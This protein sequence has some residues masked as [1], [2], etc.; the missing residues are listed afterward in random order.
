MATGINYSTLEDLNISLGSGGDIF[1][2]ESTHAGTT[3]LW[4]NGGGDVVNVRTTAGQTTVDTGTGNDVI[5]V[6]SLSAV[7]GGALNA[8]NGLVVVRAGEGTDTLNVDDS[9]DIAD[10][11]GEMTATGITGLG[12]AVG[13]GI[14]YLNLETLNVW[15]GQG[16]DSFTMHSTHTQLTNVDGGPSGDIIRIED[17]SGMTNIYG[18]TGKD[19]ITVDT[20]SP[21]FDGNLDS[22]RD[23]V[24]LDGQAGTDNF[25]VN[26]TG[27]GDYIVNVF[28]TGAPDDGTDTLTVYGTDDRDDFLL[29]A[30]THD[31]PSGV[32]FV[33]SLHGTPVTPA[34][35]VER[36]N[37]NKNLEHLTVDA[38]RGEDY[39]T[40]DDNWTKT[41]IRGDDGNDH[42][43]VGQIFKSQRDAENANIAPTD[44]FE[45]VQTT[46][47]YL[48]NGVSF[49]TTIEGN[50]G[51]DEFT[52]FRNT[53]D[54]TLLGGD[55]DDTFTIRAFAL[56]GS[57]T[58]EVTGEGGAD[59]VL[60]VINS[61]VH[62]NGGD[63][64][65]TVRVIGTEFS[66]QIVVTKDGIF[67]MGITVDYT[68]IEHLV[69]DAAEGNDEFFILSTN[70]NV[71]TRLYGGLGS[72]RF[73]VAG[74]VPRIVQGDG[75]V[76]FP[77][78]AG[79]HKVD[80]IEGPLFISGAAGKGSAGG[81]GSPVMLPGETNVMPSTGDILE[82]IGTG[83]PGSIDTMMVLTSAL[84][85]VESDLNKLIGK[86]IEVSYGP[87]LGRF[88]LIQGWATAGDQTVLTL[89]SP[90]MPADEWG[91]PVDG[92]SK[93][94]VTHLSENFFIKESEQVDIT[95]I[96]NDK[97]TA[98]QTGAL[99]ATTLTGFGMNVEGITYGDLET[100]DMFLGT[101]KDTVSVTGTMKREDGFRTVTML[102]TGAGD[103]TVT[104]NLDSAKDGF[105]VLN[106]EA[107]DDKV[108][109]STSTLPLVIFGGEGKDTIQSGEGDDIVFG[110]KGRIDYRDD[111]GRIITR[112]GL[113]LEERTLI[114]PGGS[115]STVNDVPFR[116]TDGVVRGPAYITTRDSGTGD[117]DT[118]Y[119]NDGSDIILGGAARDIVVAGDG[120]NI[121][122]GDNGYVDYVA[123]DNDPTDIDLIA[124]T[125]YAIGGNDDITTGTGSDI[126]IGGAADDTVKAG[127]GNNIV[128]GDSGRITAAAS[129]ASRF[130][131]FSLTIGLIET[132]AY[133]IGG[134][135]TI[136]A[137]SSNTECSIILG[138]QAGDTI[139]AIDGNNIVLG[140]NGYVDYV[141][142]DGD[143]STIDEIK[144]T[145]TTADGGVDIITTGT[146][147]DIVIGGRYGDNVK[148]GSG[149]NIVL[150]DSGRL[151]YVNGKLNRIETIEPADGGID[152][153]TT[154][155]G[156]DII[157]GGQAG[158]I[159]N[160]G[161]GNN[162]VLGDNGYIDYVVADGDPSDIDRIYSTDYAV[163]G[164]DI[165]TTGIGSDIVIGGTADD[166][167]KA[168]AGDNIVIGDSGQVT[169]A[170]S[171][172]ARFAGTNLTIGLIETT[173]YGIGGVDDI[174]TNGGNDIILGGEA[175]DLPINAGDGNNIVLGDDG[176][177]R[178]DSD[179]DP[180]TIDEIRSTST[181]A[182]GGVDI[183]TTGIGSDIVIGGRYGDTVNAGA[184]NNIVLGDSGRLVYV[185]GSLNR[186]ETIEPADGGIDTITTNGGSDIILGGQ[187]GDII[188]AGE[189]T[190]LVL[191]DN[192]TVD[193]LNGFYTKAWTTDTSENTGGAD[194]ISGNGGGDYIL[195]GVGGDTIYGDAATPGTNDGNDV[196]LG[197]NGIFEFNLSDAPYDGDATTLD[198][199]QTADTGLGGVDTIYGNAKDDVI[200]GGAAGDFIYGNA[201]NDLVLGDFG[202]VRFGSVTVNKLGTSNAYKE[203]PLYATTTD[204]SQGGTDTIFG[205]EDEDVLAGGAFGDNIDGG[206]QDDLI[207]GD[208]VTLNR[209]GVYNDFTNPRFRTVTGPMYDSNGNVTVGTVNQNFPSPMGTP[210]WGNWDFTLLHHDVATEAPGNTNFG[211]DYIAG[212]PDDDMIFGQLGDDAIQGDGSIDSKVNGGTAVGA[213]RN[214]NG[215]LTIRPSFEA[216]TDG[217]D[218]IEGNGGNDVIFG[219]LGQDDIIGGS[220]NLFSLTASNLR[221][222]GSDVIFGGAGTDVARNNMG[223]ELVSGHA[224][225][226]DMIL[227]DN[228]NIFRLVSIGTNGS[229]YL[230]FNYDNYNSLKIVPRAADL[231]D[232]TPGGID[233]DAAAADDI[234]FA[235]EIHGESGDDFIY[236]MVGNDVLFGE[237][238]DDDLIGG[239]G[240]DWISGG[241]GQDGVLGDDGRIYSSRNSATYGEP[242]Y[243]IAPLLATDPDT[244]F[245]NG[246][247]LNEYIYTPGKIQ[248][249]TINVA[250]ELKKTVNLTPFKLGDPEAF[251]YATQDPEFADDIIYGGWGSDFLHGGAGDD[252]ISGAEALPMYYDKPFN[253]GNV[254]KF[255]D[256]R[257]GEFGAYNEYDPWSK[258]FWNP[259]T[260]E[261]VTGGTV[262]FLLNFDQ[263][264]GPAVTDATWGTV[265]TDG[266]DIIFGDL[267]N[268][269]L[270]G[271]TG[272]DHL[273]GGYGNDL[274]NADD[275]QTTVS[276]ANT[277]PDTHP[278]YEDIAYGGAGR[279]VLI[280]NT[281]G[282]RLIDWAG[283]FNSYI[284]PFAPFGMATV[285]RTL[286]PQLPEYLYALS[287]S[288]GVDPTRS[289]D[290]GADAA[291]NGEPEGELGLVKQ[292]DIYW[293]EQTGA[294][295]DPQPGNIPGGRRDILRSSTF[296]TGKMEGFFVDSGVWTVENGALKVAAG[297]LG[298]DAAAVYNLDKMLP[299]YFEIQASITMEKPT[300]GWKANSYIIFDY[301][302]PTDFKYAGLNASVDKVQMG[303]RDATGWQVDVQAPLQIKPGTLYNVLLAVNGTNVTMLVDNKSYFSYTFAPRVIDGWAYGINEGMIGFGSDNSR[304]VYDN[305]AVQVLPPQ[306]TFEG[307]EAFP[308]TDTRIA[309]SPASGSWGTS[310]GRYDGSPVVGGDRAIS[311]VNLGL[312]HGFEVASILGLETTLNTQK[313]GG[314]V[315]DYYGPNDFKFAAID[316]GAD[317]LVIGHCT[318][319]SGWVTDATFAMTIDAGVDYVLNLSLKGTTVSASVKKVGVTNWQGIVGYV[320]NAVT[321]D[322]G[323]G[324]LTKNGSSSFDAVTVK[325]DDPAFRTMN[326]MAS[327]PAQVAADATSSITNAD[328]DAIVDEAIERWS[329]SNLADE[330]KLGIL[331]QVTFQIA[332]LS[333]LALGQ[334]TAN[335]V[336]IDVDAAGYG[337]FID[338]TPY[339]DI[340]FS[341]AKGSGE[342][343][344]HMDLLTVVMHELGHVLGFEDLNAESNALMSGTLDAG[345]RDAVGDTNNQVQGDSASLVSM[346]EA[347]GQFG[348]EESIRSQNSWL[349]AW[350]LSAAY[351][352]SYGPNKDIQIVIPR[353]EGEDNPNLRRFYGKGK[354]A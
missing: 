257:A 188:S 278:S 129:N 343:A 348:S 146:G 92:E 48:S 236:G 263:I 330:L 324:L 237:G 6:G 215:T 229:S 29:R 64:D 204:D 206:S 295:D 140:D 205:N 247:V 168:G 218:Y 340:E 9:G 88:W 154:N 240:N 22:T 286:Q 31:Y 189:G 82:F 281:G 51:E 328:L 270:V 78:A 26:V 93:F 44:E 235:D 282:D 124:S 287:K 239:Y 176:Y 116:Q 98:D 318:A 127:A 196:I 5:N 159:I 126:V 249:S 35:Q 316:A 10:N 207:F 14:D 65:D 81:L 122:F 174:T 310:N 132:I 198:R 157:L 243:G 27:S 191:G 253:Q 327:A 177:L 200:L 97:A 121:V 63:G 137:S 33:A 256:Y 329:E 52:V 323:F 162:I 148:A 53:A 59:H 220:S 321:V 142:G 219:N 172:A 18:G 353:Q 30:S 102:N 202:E 303:H 242:L 244:R 139:T 28:E 61:P 223:D 32:A 75:T 354:R 24:N 230:T 346:D 269:W 301:Y 194:T 134:I 94:A 45:T 57:H 133:G 163:G 161:D 158:D 231:L 118:I 315:F 274:M 227:G 171:N 182:N 114:I 2:I 58:T 279:D 167:V 42:F 246:D 210:V 254:L 351:N 178:Y 84:L 225:D 136:T 291:R 60:Y 195:G 49:D 349:N 261:F 143:P 86:T 170:S 112:L 125:D 342:V 216:T 100:L 41:T 25:I 252:A 90:T 211:N 47:G 91:M 131:G 284:V 190:D 197:D 232:Y 296:N 77:G 138:G 3:D 130:A 13:K 147:N 40:L 251:D 151:V 234:G 179:N 115:E 250:G 248:Q 233:Y 272:K 186:I 107:G 222:D 259:D 11:T 67:G 224:R 36:I 317:K 184:G 68:Q 95:T 76:L 297:S 155:G 181:T 113:G 145:S 156:S 320:F 337:W 15:L 341:G 199:V 302:S 123:L 350:L 268:D 17:A 128:I 12:M 271:G 39:F 71:E 70:S 352:D 305:I 108:F 43:Q 226:A 304:G 1:T 288:D 37:Y 265:H 299:C 241:T 38:Q 135:D 264:E 306:M 69:I 79:S 345:E 99:T 23:T 19:D 153:I 325:T 203:Y 180:S 298:G 255:G 165:I 312:G 56:E 20:L 238:Q 292:K 141:V 277:A 8:I 339:D 87:G 307:T 120:N 273:Y 309:L 217:D 322:G 335:T 338:T 258:V 175:G 214:P 285:S 334:A 16:I 228:G 185:N 50:A 144:S 149:N 201:G 62:I 105:F 193:M 311:L 326:M 119:G 283:E 73:Y 276:N 109:A 300:A 164:N 314:L 333:G 96:F 289:A 183:I 46:R 150:G 319:K 336:L 290:T 275:Y 331:D 101:G 266:N 344:G 169:A 308:D 103:D 55:D 293:H 173:A 280:G 294:P 332:D 85:G 21:L 152:T 34:T 89:K 187:G 83:G 209:V 221:P 262:E 54:L 72:D 110:D 66:D 213:L 111:S 80:G 208:N 212:G 166:T 106:T 160:A 313:T 347:K 117:I 260:G 7:K 4:A 104:V 267:G 192:G 74:D 245:S